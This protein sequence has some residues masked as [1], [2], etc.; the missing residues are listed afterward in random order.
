MYMANLRIYVRFRT[1]KWEDERTYRH[2]VYHVVVRSNAGKFMEYKVVQCKP[3]V[4][5]AAAMWLAWSQ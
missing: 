5:A 1:K 3:K 2:Q 4:T